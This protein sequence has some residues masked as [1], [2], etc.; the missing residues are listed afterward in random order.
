MS[1]SKQ[2]SLLDPS[3]QKPIISSTRFWVQMAADL[4]R[5]GVSNAREMK[6]RLYFQIFTLWLNATP[7]SEIFNS[8]KPGMYGTRLRYFEFD[9]P[10]NIFCMYSNLLNMMNLDCPK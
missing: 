9:E 3:S 8:S 5:L 1:V 6:C 7:F 4:E 10:S 2:P